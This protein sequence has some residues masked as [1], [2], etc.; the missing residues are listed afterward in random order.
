MWTTCFLEKPEQVK[1]MI[2]YPILVQK[3]N[4][5]PLLKG[6]VCVKDLGWKLY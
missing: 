3:Q 6:C 1:N 2:D 4:F 5:E